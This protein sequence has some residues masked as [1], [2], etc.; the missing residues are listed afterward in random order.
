MNITNR[1]IVGAIAGAAVDQVLGN[2]ASDD[3]VVGGALGAL[4]GRLAEID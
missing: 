2:A 1:L 4:E 3:A